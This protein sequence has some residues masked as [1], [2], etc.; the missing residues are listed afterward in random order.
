MDGDTL[1]NYAYFLNGF[2]PEID[3]LAKTALEDFRDN[4]GL[5]AETLE[6]AQ[7]RLFSGNSDIL[8]A[9]LGFDSFGNQPIL[10]TTRLVEIPSFCSRQRHRVPLS[11]IPAS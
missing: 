5:S 9:R 3:S 6:Q 1:S 11:I 7:V 4:S 8:K 10:K 2:D